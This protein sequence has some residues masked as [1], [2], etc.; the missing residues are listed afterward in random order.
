MNEKRK[1]GL[2]EKDINSIISILRLNI[3]IDKIVLFGSR[4]KGNY[5]DGSDIDIA[6]KG[7]NLKLDDILNAKVSFDSLSLPY[8]I[9]LI[10]Y[11]RVEEVELINHIDRIGLVLY[12]K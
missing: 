9:D 8:K 3:K 5:N 6:V 2:L 4:A 10:I 1:Y 12:E 7:K 11:D